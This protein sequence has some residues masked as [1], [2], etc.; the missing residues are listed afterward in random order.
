MQKRILLLEPYEMVAEALT[1]CLRHLDYDVDV[2]TTGELDAS[3]LRGG[4]YDCVL[5]NLD[6]N[7]PNTRQGGLKLAEM[8]TSL[9]M[10]VVMI[11]DYRLARDTLSAKGW[12]HIAKPFTIDK[13][14]QV[15]AQAVENPPLPDGPP[16]SGS[17]R[18]QTPAR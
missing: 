16:P 9:G 15:I 2:V 13:L 17:Q 8:A 3:R 1:D 11:P 5:I 6:Q 4:R 12:L 18:P 14:Q 7:R 10:P